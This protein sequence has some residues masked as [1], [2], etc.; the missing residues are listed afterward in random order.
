VSRWGDAFAALSGGADTL[1][2]IRHSSEAPATVSQSVNSVTLTAA[3]E[4]AISSS[5]SAVATWGDTNKKRAAIVE[6][7]GKIPQAW[8]E[9]FARL[10]PAHPPSHMPQ[11]RWHSFINDCGRFLD[12]G[13]AANAAALGW[14]PFDIFGCDRDRPFTRID[15]AGLLWLLNGDRLVALAENIA[16]I[17]TRTDARQT[18]RRRSGASG[19]VLPWELPDAHRG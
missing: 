16:T 14:D 3:T 13:F 12:G 5:E 10:N 8:A 4:P 15:Q 17:E 19:R 2:T 9:G 11:R 7:D 18:Y 6:H 1:D